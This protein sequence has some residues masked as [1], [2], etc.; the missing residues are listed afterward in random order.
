MQS[1]KAINQPRRTFQLSTLNFQ[2]SS[3][4]HL[5][6]QEDGL[7]GVFVV[8]ADGEGNKERG[9]GVYVVC[10]YFQFNDGSISVVFHKTDTTGLSP[11]NF[12]S[13]AYSYEDKTAKF[14]KGDP[15]SPYYGKLTYTIS[16][17]IIPADAD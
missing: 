12:K 16:A 3:L 10:V 1:A 4:F 14:P 2:L 13:S 6:F 7:G 17:D 9:G 15:N 8:H 11:Y 5:V